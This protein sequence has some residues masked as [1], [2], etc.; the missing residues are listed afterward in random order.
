MKLHHLHIRNIHSLAGDQ[1][2]HFT[3][4]P[5]GDAG[6]FA[7]TGPTGS[8]KSTLLDAITLSLYNR[9]SRTQKAITVKVIAEEGLIITHHA[10]SC[11]AELTFSIDEKMYRA[12]WSMDRN[13]KG[14]LRERKHEISSVDSGEIL[15]AGKK[16]APEFIRELIGLTYE[17]FTQA[18]VLSQGKFD[19][20]I[21]AKVDDRYKLLEDL[22]GGERYRL[23]GKK[24][25]EIYRDTKSN[26]HDLETELSAVE[27]LPDEVVSQMEKEISALVK[28]ISELK[29]KRDTL[30]TL[31]QQLSNW[32]Q[33]TT[34]LKNVET[35]LQALQTKIAEFAPLEKK[36]SAHQRWMPKLHVYHRGVTAASNLET[37]LQESQ[38][39]QATLNETQKDLGEK[40]ADAR[41]KWGFQGTPAAG[42]TVV[43]E[44]TEPLQNHLDE[45]VAEITK[46]ME[47]ERELRTE[48]KTTYGAA[49]A[50]LERI[51]S[52][53]PE[54]D[55]KFSA[56]TGLE[57]EKRLEELTAE[58]QKFEPIEEAVDVLE[59]QH[60]QLKTVLL[61]AQH[62]DSLEKSLS[63]VN[64]RIG[65][66]TTGLEKA[67]E[68]LE[69]VQ[70]SITRTAAQID[71]IR[72]DIDR[73]KAEE[74]LAGYRTEL[75]DGMPCPLCGAHHHPYTT[76]PPQP[77]D[78]E[79]LG[80]AAGLGEDSGLGEDTAFMEKAEPGQAENEMSAQDNPPQNSEAGEGEA[81]EG[82]NGVHQ[83]EATPQN[84]LTDALRERLEHQEE[85]KNLEREW[86]ANHG[87]LQGSL[88]S[89]LANKREL[90]AQIA[91]QR[92]VLQKATSLS[93]AADIE[94]ALV[95][96]KERIKQRLRQSEIENLERALAELTT[97]F[98]T[99]ENQRKA[100]NDAS[101]KRAARYAGTDIHTDARNFMRTWT[102]RANLLDQAK[103]ELEKLR[104]RI[105]AHN[106]ALKGVANEL[107]APVREAGLASWQ[108][109]GNEVLPEGEA[110]K[111][112]AAWEQL[113]TGKTTL[114][115]K[116]SDLVKVNEAGRA[117][118]YDQLDAEK[119]SA[120]LASAEQEWQDQVSLRASLETRLNTDKEQRERR[121]KYE[122]KLGNLGK[123]LDRWGRLNQLIGNA[124]GSVFSRFVQEITLM[125]LVQMANER[126]R[127]GLSDRFELEIGDGGDLFVRD[128]D[129][130]MSKRS[131]HS[132]SGGETFK[133]SLAMAMGLSDLASHRVNIESLFI[134]EGFGSLDPESLE[135]AMEALER[136]Q[137]DGDK[138]VGVISHVSEMKERIGTQIELVP[139]G[140]GLSELKIRVG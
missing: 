106:Q 66:H 83:P 2:V 12:S 135:E 63:E 138:S 118:G 1:K 34:D 56:Q 115:Q 85:L 3:S 127:Q 33:A 51:G 93:K 65:T 80:N 48:C 104:L 91:E 108:E 95:E 97:L 5:L 42:E 71:E 18:M 9:I 117:A 36:L 40:I 109:I 59:Q 37:D 10:E 28:T 21:K 69:R 54:W 134:D 92:D 14:E 44:L 61:I 67:A 20:L 23:I 125:Q 41:I 128:A 137:Q 102:D 89:E 88:N 26:L 27:V 119:T 90:I 8:G 43:S 139:V 75:R 52:A 55:M 96:C 112:A 140:N 129:L 116:R 121:K 124:S 87:E 64:N 17:Q 136:M 24:T 50:I 6:L 72:A 78:A 53:A 130:G 38:R 114:T 103:K 84:S 94:S 126:L 86:I 76:H 39:T 4:G 120:Q 35:E 81:G 25:Y 100:L 133:V 47:V 122:D 111:L 29:Q 30:E 77:S 131:I 99:Y 11:L 73:R 79:G 60:E 57:I 82:E 74:G 32:R 46:L 58:K 101:A 7:I 31:L 22:V 123:E 62:R 19:E 107:E 113:K 13:R 15:A 132:L 98:V 16:E 68:A 49:E 70:E 110:A 105:E 45:V